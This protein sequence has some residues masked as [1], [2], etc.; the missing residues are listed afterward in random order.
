L[1]R[2]WTDLYEKGEKMN[3]VWK[4]FYKKF[5]H[6]EEADNREDMIIWGEAFRKWSNDIIALTKCVLQVEDVIKGKTRSI[7]A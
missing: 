7:T 3:Y 2:S 5:K 4:T 6:A 1:S